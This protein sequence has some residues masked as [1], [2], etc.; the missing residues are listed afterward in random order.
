MTINLDIIS[1]SSHITVYL[2]YVVD[3]SWG[4][5]CFVTW[6]RQQIFLYGTKCLQ[7]TRFNISVRR[8]SV[9]RYCTGC[10]CHLKQTVLQDQI[11]LGH[12]QRADICIPAADT[13]QTAASLYMKKLN[14]MSCWCESF[15]SLFANFISF[16]IRIFQCL[17]WG[18]LVPEIECWSGELL[19]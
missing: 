5:S 13:I 11:T 1:L 10:N 12:I 7:S 3:W 15:V 16:G 17:E 19:F 2:L 4:V 8:Y 9:A 6:R 14:R 18:Q